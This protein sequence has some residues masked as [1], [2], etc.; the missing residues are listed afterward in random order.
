M[1]RARARL[2]T[3]KHSGSAR[4]TSWR[5]GH[6]TTCCLEVRALV[7]GG[8]YCSRSDPSY[9]APEDSTMTR[10]TSLRVP[11][12]PRIRATRNLLRVYGAFGGV[13]SS[14]SQA[15]GEHN[16]RVC[17]TRMEIPRHA[18]HR[19]LE[20]E[21]PGTG[22]QGQFWSLKPG[23]AR[24]SAPDSGISFPPMF[25]RGVDF[26]LGAAALPQGLST[27]RRGR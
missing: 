24:R 19:P 2:G 25:A 5:G 11:D 20:P 12:A 27:V 26:R 18:E 21:V 16:V 3:R 15:W 14:S 8:D 22:A 23:L 9:A 10:G 13:G 17:P 7:R 6:S 4:I 1:P